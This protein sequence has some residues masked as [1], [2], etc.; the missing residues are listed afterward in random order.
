MLDFD[1]LPGMTEVALLTEVKRQ[2]KKT[3]QVIR[4]NKSFGPHIKNIMNIIGENLYLKK[5]ILLC[6]MISCALA[7]ALGWATDAS[8]HKLI[9]CSY[10]HDFPLLPYPKLHKIKDLEEFERISTNLS[11][12]E[13]EIFLNHPRL[14]ADIVER[15]KNAPKEANVVILQHHELPNRAG[16]PAKLQTVRIIPFAALLAISIDFSQYM[17]EHSDWSKSNYLDLAWKKFKGGIFR[18][19][20]RK[21]A[22]VEIE[23]TT[24]SDK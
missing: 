11:E 7:K 12:R 18:K 9:Y 13:Q 16:F 6:S 19:I 23:N 17:L 3:T 4:N 5:R 2:A 21:L 22:I 24:S 15:D 10:L 20:I 8:F 1:L 14:A